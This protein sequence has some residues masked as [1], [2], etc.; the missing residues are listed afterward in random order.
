MNH[1]PTTQNPP[2]P[3]HAALPEL[4]LALANRTRVV[5]EAPPGAGKTTA[6]PL[7]L[8]DAPWLAGRKIVM[9]EPRR[10]AARAAATFMA[11]SL[12]ESVGETVGYRIRFEA[13]VSAGTRIEV[14]TEGI[15]TRLIQSDPELSGIG[16]LIFDEFHERH[17]ATDLGLAL[18]LDA[19]AGLR[20]DLRLLIM[21]ATLD[22]ERLARW[23][24][25][26]RVTSEGRSFP[27][28]TEY[29]PARRDEPLAAH[30][31]RATRQALDS[32]EGD[33]LV[34]L[35]G[36]REIDAAARLLDLPAHVDVLPLHGDLP[37]EAQAAA[38]RPAAPDRRHVV[39][40]TNVAE[41]SV[42]LPGVRTVIDSGLA[43]VSRFDP[44]SGF[45][46]LVQEFIA[47]DSATQ[48]AGRAARLGP[49]LVIRLWGQDKRLA[50]ERR[51]E[52]LDADLA[53]LALELAAWGGREMRFLTPP[54]PGALAQAIDTL[55]QLDALD[56]QERITAHGRRLAHIGTHPRLANLVLHAG[57]NGLAADTLALI[58]A[59][60]PLQGEAR[61]SEDWRERFAALAALRAGRAPGAASASA[62]RSI[63]HSA[64]QWRRRLELPESG[65]PSRT[66]IGDL[67]LHAFPDRIARLVS[68][69]RYQLASGRGASLR[70]GSA[71]TGE[72]WL[73]VSELSGLGGDAR[74]A[75]AA[76][77]DEAQLQR[78]YGEHFHTTR[79][80]EFDSNDRVVAR[81]QKRFA[82]IVL[83]EHIEPVRDAEALIAAQL[84]RI[85]QRGL[86]VLPFTDHQ[87]R[88]RERAQFLRS[89]DGFADLPDV[90]D[91]GLLATLESWLAPFLT[92]ISKLES[93]P[94]DRL[95]EA[96]FSQLSY[97]DRQRIELEAP[98]SFLAPSGQRRRIEYG[99][100]PVLAIK[101]Q[102]L[103]GLPES[104]RIAGG[105]V[106]L[107]L[108]L[109]SPGG[110]PIQVTQDLRSF[111]DRTYAE[112]RKE[113]KGRYPKHPWPDDPWTATATHRAKPRG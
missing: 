55:K 23:C 77:F 57:R 50:P 80:I 90:S 12:G 27:L 49:G 19:Q 24:D 89:I 94:A 101:L 45:A 75:K 29:L 99:A 92:G 53:P 47:L 40:S 59:R 109:L 11:S 2:L 41:S 70:S 65:E 35:P 88:W 46:T 37:I 93:L 64:R 91:A 6:V 34:F 61:F 83:S 13:K 79:V 82:A 56:D 106:P 42:T 69:E 76:P 31:A 85:R 63:D 14:V 9:L 22:G 3:I 1:E 32:G 17:L 18:A 58:E 60:D 72:P 8:L 74:I 98:E 25:A 48:R 81:V 54:P 7:A 39:L 84:T 10:I 16:C 26:A 87:Q 4:K 110:R 33:V 112:V 105:K 73:A 97:A 30:V 113:L 66:A 103:F 78:H 95:G 15:L 20:E 36:K 86:R 104:P 44:A 51:A 62:L 96:L 68:G 67:L 38:L 28:R 102:E 52:I 108:H 107:T 111:W 43:R 71:L 5:L 100:Q 21:S